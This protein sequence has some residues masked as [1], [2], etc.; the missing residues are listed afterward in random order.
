MATV[1]GYE[2]V[3]ASGSQTILNSV[4]FDIKDKTGYR[5]NIQI[6]RSPTGNC[7]LA[8]IGYLNQL[9]ASVKV[10]A[11]VQAIIREAFRLLGH[12][13]LLVMLDVNESI[14]KLVEAC[15]NVTHKTP[16]KSTNGNMMC[17]FLVKLD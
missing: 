10:R 4:L 5:R 6:V 11:E 16:Y 13:P 9:L 12:D 3:V 17:M 7:Q 14:I 2:V 8:C 15:F 1:L